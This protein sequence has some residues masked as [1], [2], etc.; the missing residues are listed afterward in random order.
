MNTDHKVQK[1]IE[2]GILPDPNYL[3][4]EKEINRYG[5][6]VWDHKTGGTIQ[7]MNG[8]SFNNAKQ[9]MALPG[10]RSGIK[11]FGFRG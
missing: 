1:L 5:I 4:R 2:M 9:Y 3:P 6:M 10:H 7:V 8:S 11:K